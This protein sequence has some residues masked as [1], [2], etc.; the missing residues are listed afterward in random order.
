[1][2]ARLPIPAT[3]HH[4]HPAPQVA[5]KAAVGG[6]FDLIDQDG[7]RFTHQDLLGQFSV[8]YFGFTHC[9]DI[10]PDELEKLGEALDKI[11]QQTG[12][13]VGA[14][15]VPKGLLAVWLRLAAAV[16]CVQHACKCVAE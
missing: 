9:P 8:M 3:T 12:V 14:G 4:H 15:R 13:Q 6:P 7:K 10:C 11:E 5:G 16:C 1:M 2:P